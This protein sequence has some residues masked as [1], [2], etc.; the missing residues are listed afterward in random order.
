VHGHDLA[1]G[2]G[3]TDV[4]VGSQLF[5]SWNRLFLNGAVQYAIRTKGDFGYEAADD[6]TWSGG[7]GMFALTAHDYTLGVYAAISGESKGKD[8]V[9]GIKA[10]DTARTGVYVGPGML[11]TWGAP[12]AVDLSL[13][14]SVIQNNSALQVV[15]DYRLRGGVTWR[16]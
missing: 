15:P 13:D 11:L 2:S 8:R 9:V 16:F 14:L 4:V 12:L 7:P 5:A 10:D 1:L 3:S 6:L